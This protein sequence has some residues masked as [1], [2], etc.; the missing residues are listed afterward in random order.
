MTAIHNPIDGAA[1]G[2]VQPATPAEIDAAFDQAGKAQQAWAQTSATERGRRLREVADL[3]RERAH[4]FAALETRNTGKPLRNTLGEAE[5]AALAFEYYAGWADKVTGTTIPVGGDHHTYTLREPRGIAVGIVPWNVPYV[6]AALKVAPA[7]AFGNAILLK[8]A[9]ETPL[10]ALL[11]AEVL[12]SSSLPGG[13]M[14]VLPGG[15]DVGAQLVAHLRA[16]VVA[17]TGFHETGRRVAEAAGRQLTPVTLELGGKNPQLIFADAD[18]DA[19]VQGVMLGGYSQCGQMCIAGSRVFVQDEIY[20]EVAERLAAE[21]SALRVGDPRDAD[22]TVGPQTTRRQ[23]DKTLG[24]IDAGRAEGATVLAQVAVPDKPG[25]AGGFYVPPTLFTDTDPGMRVM[26]EEIFGPVVSLGRFRDEADAVAQAGESDFGLAA[27][28]WTSDVGRAH[29]LARALDVGTVWINT[30]RVL[31]VLV[32]FGGFRLSG[33]GQEGGEEAIRLYT[34]SKS[35]WTSLQPG[36]PAG[37][38]L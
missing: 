26:R 17:F 6:F 38:R 1:I 20:D 33:Y 14:H 4:E 34:R 13:L 7:L 10:S 28:V 19:A 5:R 22:T 15:G 21:V 11:L 37:Y 3:L 2:D 18:L 24:L 36:L 25:I 30:Y 23:A 16:D 31:S 32:P 27:G 8:P 9:A 29:R 12:A 35:V